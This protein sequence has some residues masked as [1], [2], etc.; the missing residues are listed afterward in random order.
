M[1]QDENYNEWFLQ[2]YYYI[3]ENEFNSQIKND[4]EIA[5]PILINRLANLQN[6][7]SIE[8]LDIRI[9]NLDISYNYLLNAFKTISGGNELLQLLDL[10]SN[11]YEFKN[12]FDN[13]IEFN[14]DNSYIFFN[15][16]ICLNSRIY[17]FNNESIYDL[18]NIDNSNNI[19]LNLKQ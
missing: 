6:K 18:S 4:I 16:D 7:T 9:N 15:H 12:T 8:S 17:N 13:F 10:S 3:N 1:S 11:F 19:V 2:T 14:L 5:R